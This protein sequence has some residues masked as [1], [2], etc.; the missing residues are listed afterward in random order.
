MET[1][2]HLFPFV[3]PYRRLAVLSIICTIF[4]SVLW[5]GNLSTV[6]PM[7]RVLFQDKNL[8]QYV[9]EQIELTQADIEQRNAAIE[10]LAPDD[11]ERRARAQ[12]YQ[13]DATR[14]LALLTTTWNYVLP[15]VP[16]DR[17]NTI[18][19]IFGCF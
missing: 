2:S 8:H 6:L 17:F 14:Q 7:V 9:D 1:V 13:S 12:Q 19:L 11:V 16:V 3:W 4:I 10:Q 5:A 15:Y 18:A